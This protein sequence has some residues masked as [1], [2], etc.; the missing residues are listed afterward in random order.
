MGIL[1]T[2]LTSIN[3]LLL[4]I[5]HCRTIKFRCNM[6]HIYISNKNK[7]RF[8]YSVEFHDVLV[9]SFQVVLKPSYNFL[10]LV[11]IKLSDET[12]F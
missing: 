12:Q 10:R 1:L 11:Q 5:H 4:I 3:S 8:N 7:T 6:F 2:V 9:R